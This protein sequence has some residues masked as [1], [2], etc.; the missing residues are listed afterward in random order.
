MLMYVIIQSIPVGSNQMID[1]FRKYTKESISFIFTLDISF[2][3]FSIA[4]ASLFNS[5]GFNI[6]IILLILFLNI[7]PFILFTN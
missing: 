5:Y 4:F 2:I 1:I 7:I 6:N 3:L